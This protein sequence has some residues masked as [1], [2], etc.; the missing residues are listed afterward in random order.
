MSHFLQNQCH[1]LSG[2]SI[3]KGS[4]PTV[5][6]SSSSS[7]AIASSVTRSAGIGS[8]SED[9]TFCGTTGS[10]NEGRNQAFQAYQTISKEP[11]FEPCFLCAL[12]YDQPLHWGLRKW[13]CKLCTESLHRTGAFC[14]SRQWSRRSRWSIHNSISS[15]R[16]HKSGS[17]LGCCSHRE[18][19][20]TASARCRSKSQIWQ[21]DW[22]NTSRWHWFFAQA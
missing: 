14:Y 8:T 1:S 20:S 6:F 9:N 10:R 21:L 13:D 2:K 3:P 17:S 5:S 22:R 4:S 18:H 7:D 16:G 11:P 15:G 19:S 12:S